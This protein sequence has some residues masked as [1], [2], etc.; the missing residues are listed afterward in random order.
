MNTFDYI[1]VSTAVTDR[2]YA[3]GAG[4]VEEQLGG[5]GVYALSGIRL[6]TENCCLVT[7]IG[8]DFPERHAEWFRRNRCTMEGLMVKDPHTAV[9]QIRYFA[10]GERIETPPFG[11]E[12]YRK[13]EASPAELEPWLK[14]ARGVYIFK[15]CDAAYWE[16]VLEM[17]QRYGFRLLWEINADSAVPE[18]LEQ[19][20]GIA[21]QC[22]IFSINKTESLRMLSA[23]S[24]EEA[25]GQLGKWE[26]PLIFLR[27]G[28]KG[29][30]MLSGGSVSSVPP[31]KDPV[32]KDPTGCGNGSC[33]AVL[34]GFC[35]GFGPVR[36]G[37]MGSISA[38][39]IM[40]QY[41]PP[42]TTQDDTENAFTLLSQMEGQYH[43]EE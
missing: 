5:A 14:S 9:S 43:E 42:V 36:C 18:R 3:H 32:M 12:H 13:M 17:K 35:E 10:D 11:A 30:L 20:R 33:A 1:I 21:K 38:A 4:R 34:Y 31:V 26:V 37:L 16:S 6:W 41:G 25:A 27:A 8:R 23:S 24:L 39:H 2:V 40:E 28:E 22:D 19:V 7:G 29:A 15:E